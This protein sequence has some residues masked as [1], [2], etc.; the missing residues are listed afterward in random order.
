MSLPNITSLAH[1]VM[2]DS[3]LAREADFTISNMAS[4]ANIQASFSKPVSPPCTPCP[5]GNETSIE[6]TN[7]VLSM[8][9]DEGAGGG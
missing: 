2:G 3:W 6:Q 8:D 4:L 7:F 5:A 9:E 1:C